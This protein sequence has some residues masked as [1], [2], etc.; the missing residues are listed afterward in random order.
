MQPS[1]S[2]CSVGAD[3][4]CP[5][6]SDI[7]NHE[8]YME[9]HRG[10]RLPSRC[11]L[12]LPTTR[13]K[14]SVWTCLSRMPPSHGL[15]D[16]SV[17][18][19]TNIPRSLKQR[20]IISQ[21]MGAA[22]PAGTQS[23]VSSDCVLSKVPGAVVSAEGSPVAG[24]LSPVLAGGRRARSLAMWGSLQSSWPCRASDLGQNQEEALCPS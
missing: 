4:S 2:G 23:Q 3:G 8:E 1:P 17:E 20:R 15:C 6:T 5:I 9:S 7:H 21:S 13:K 12:I 16:L 11:S 10:P 14:A 24:G 22:Q 18:L 19:G